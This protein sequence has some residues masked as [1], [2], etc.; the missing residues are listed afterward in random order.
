M[1]IIG[2]AAPTGVRQGPCSWPLLGDCPDLDEV[3][4]QD[5][6]GEEIADAL[7]TWATSFLWRWTGRVYG[8][9]PVVIRPRRVD[10]PRST[11]AGDVSGWGPVLVGGVW[12]NLS[13][14][15]C[16]GDCGCG[17]EATTVRLPGPVAAVTAVTVD[18]S[19]LDSSAYGVDD[20]GT[21]VRHDGGV[22]PG[23]QDLTLPAGEVGT[24]TVAYDWGIPVPVDG[25]LA[26]GRLA[27][28]LAK[29][30]VGADGCKLPERV[31]TITREGVTVGFLDPFDGLN[32]GRTGLWDVDAWVASVTRPPARSQVYSPDRRVH[33]R[34]TQDGLVA[35][36]V[37]A[38]YPWYA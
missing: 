35:P 38:P 2:T 14:G 5:Y 12:R 34:S 26:A 9:C 22:W 36:P 3:A 1:P 4:G 17:D 11:F 19:T 15:A 8:V 32:D 13:C 37:D 21:L 28:E 20:Y 30:Y 16:A 25:Q 33:A 6:G 23:C 7:V 10:C 27:C 24:W 18:G 29:A 31:Q